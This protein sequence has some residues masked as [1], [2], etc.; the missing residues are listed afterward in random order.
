MSDL[1]LCVNKP[2]KHFNEKTYRLSRARRCFRRSQSA[3][4]WTKA[5]FFDVLS[6]LDDDAAPVAADAAGA[7]FGFVSS[8]EAATIASAC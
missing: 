2:S 5:H 4:S 7:G 6:G 1:F 3:K 8:C